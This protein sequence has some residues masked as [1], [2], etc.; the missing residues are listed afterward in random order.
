[1]LNLPD[2]QIHS[3]IYQ[4]AN[5]IVYRGYNPANN[6]PVILKLLRE[7]YPTPAELTRY[8]QEYRLTHQ[9]NIS[10]VIKAEALIEYGNTFIIVFEDFG[11]ESLKQLLQLQKFSLQ[12]CLQ[13]GIKI[14]ESLGNIHHAGIIHK[15]INPANIVYN[16]KT[17]QLKIID[18][19]IATLLNSENPTLQNPSV[20]EGTLAYISPEQTGRMNR[21]LD[22]RSDFYS[23]GV[24]L[25]EL[26]TGKLP[27][28]T[29]D[30]LELLHCHLAKQALS[31]SS[32]HSTLITHQLS[33]KE[34]AIL[35]II[36]QMSQKLMAKTAEE[37]YQSAWG[38][39]ADLEACLSRLE[40]NEKI[41]PFILGEKDRCDRFLIPE[42]LYGREQEIATL[43]AAFNAIAKKEG[44]IRNK[45]ILVSGYSGI[46]KSALVKE[47]YKPITEARGY[48]IWGKFEQ[49][50]R[51][52]P[53]SAVAIAFQSLIKQIL[54][55][56]AQALQQWKEKL[57]KALGENAQLIID[58][59]PEVELIIGKQKKIAGLSGIEAQN[60]FNWVFHRFMQVMA[61]SEHPLVLFIDDLQWADS[62]TLKL[63]QV[64]IT[65]T[66][67]EHLLLIGAY[68][69]N[70]VDTTHP[71][72]LVLEEL[73]KARI[74][75]DILH[76]KPLAQDSIDQLII[77]TLLCDC[78][79]SLSKLT[80]AKTQGNPFF[81]KEFIKT[82]YQEKLINFD[83]TKQQWS[84]NIEQIEE[85]NITD[86]VVE[87]MMSNLQKLSSVTQN[88]LS[89]AACLGSSFELRTLVIV[90][91][92]SSQEIF[93]KLS[94]AISIGL[95]IPTSDLDDQ[96]LYQD[97]KFLHD[98]I[99]QAA[100]SLIESSQLATLNL[101]IA[102][103]LLQNLSLEELDDKIFLIVD[104]Y[105][106]GKD[107]IDD[108]QEKEKL[109]NLNLQV[110]LKAKAS[111][112]FQSANRYLKIA[113]NLLNRDSWQ[114]NYQLTLEV[115]TTTAEITYIVNDYEQSLLFCET[116]KKQAK[117]VLDQVKV[118]QNQ[119]AIYIAQTKM[120]LAL[121]TAQEI[122]KLLDVSLI[123]EEPKIANSQDIMKLPEMVDEEKK[124]ALEILVS[125]FAPTYLH[126]SELLFPVS[127]TTIHLCLKYGN[128]SLS[129]N[130]YTW[131]V[132]IV[133]C[134]KNE[135]KFA[136]Q[137]GKK[138]LNLANNYS[139]ENKDHR[140]INPFYGNL[141]PW[142]KHY[143]ECT[144]PLKNA[145]QTLFEMGD[146]EYA[147]HCMFDYSAMA[148]AMGINLAEL[149]REL[150]YFMSL[151][152]NMGQ[153]LVIKLIN[154]LLGSIKKIINGSPNDL[155]ILS[156]NPDDYFEE[157]ESLEVFSNMD[158]GHVY[159]YFGQ[160]KKAYL[161]FQKN[162][163]HQGFMRAYFP[164]VKNNF[165]YSL[166]SLALY[167]QAS[168]EEQ[169]KYL[170]IVN[171][172]QKQMKIWA[173][174]AP[175]NFQHKYDLVAAETARVLGNTLEAIE[176]Y[177]QAI[178]RAK[179]NQ[180]VHEEALANELAAYFYLAR[181]QTKIAA[182]YLNDAHY[183]YLK[184][185]ANAKVKAL[186]SEYP[187][188]LTQFSNR[189]YLDLNTTLSNT[190]TRNLNEQ[191]DLATVIKTSKALSQEAKLENLLLLLSK[192]LVKN[193]GAQTGLI[194]L[195]KE[196]KL[197]LEI[198]HQLDDVNNNLEHKSNQ[199]LP[200][201]II[202]YVQRTQ[203]ILVLDNASSTGI[204]TKDKY[205]QNHQTKSVLCLPLLSQGKTIGILYLENNLSDCVFNEDRLEVV[206]LI[207]S[208]A[209]I[210]IE[211]ALLRKQEENQIYS[212]QVGGCLEPNSPTYVVRKAD[213]DL[214]QAL[215]KGEFCYV[216][217]SRHMGK[218]SLRVQ[219][220]Q[221]LSQEGYACSAIDLTAIG[222]SN[223]KE[224]QWYAGLIYKLVNSFHLSERFNFRDWWKSLDFLS[225]M[226]KFSEFIEQV[227]L[228]QIQSKII[229]F[230]DEI[231]STISLK[232]STDD[233]F[234]S[235]R[236]IYNA[237]AE[238]KE[239]HRLSFVLLGVATPSSLIQNKDHT[240]FNIG[241]A[242]TLAGFKWE[243]IK[244]LVKGLEGKY[245]QA[246]LLV[247]EVLIWT[248]GQPFLTQKICNL[249]RQSTQVIESGQE[250]EWV[251]NLVTTQIIDNWETQDEP[252]HLKT[253]RDRLLQSQNSV[254]LLQLLQWILTEGKVLLDSSA[255]QRELLLSGIVSQEDQYLV[256]FN[257]IYQQ[258]FTL[259]WLEERILSIRSN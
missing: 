84:W 237:R 245:A 55:E 159:F 137:L 215:N 54:C 21:S 51:D 235:I 109:I 220:M 158:Q 10:G 102:R 121:D 175:M 141:L 17:K 142:I 135:L 162:L 71:L 115:Y 176:L 234:A 256:M 192:F 186:E 156:E 31:V 193:T 35:E 146:I 184:W 169:Q 1:M 258:V 208:Q 249:I 209:A 80:L 74:S 13:L 79:S 114:T 128:T 145:I 222:S 199:N 50:Q 171:T 216:L 62:A 223:L 41:Q 181:K 100:H 45:L 38:I 177:D 105:N 224:E 205:I 178:A 107:L 82:L 198:T 139:F 103:L 230:I 48:F 95:I 46:G 23:L 36:D 22:Y 6:K 111:A 86:N 101:R 64:L 49:Y 149:E 236:A 124:A 56:S 93:E 217:N 112:A 96:L 201:G 227:L 212:Y 9:L 24:S 7:N 14:S 233:F 138:A 179:A 97:Y 254:D 123:Y 127:Y 88:I 147:G 240:P 16:P 248:C 157:T 206:K 168:A 33:E 170:A 165:Y 173:E 69:D 259:D 52:I 231:D 172:N 28:E 130:A 53:Y 27:F 60:R 194:F 72:T 122:L 246:E 58:V 78:V 195:E 99:Q 152:Q 19:G 110:A 197:Q 242:I 221:Q 20:L 34:I 174:N 131:Y 4:S 252:Q 94:E 155:Q 257:P 251:A 241:T 44:A 153:G 117:T 187:Q 154:L 68:R 232:F 163:K 66:Q 151:L 70:E 211:N 167:N 202:N 164:W 57:V 26:I 161:E 247:K 108:D 87:L 119:I 136:Y 85:Q 42:K 18:F 188:L 90:A 47:L 253:I 144:K 148:Y 43:L 238:R 113:I 180:Y 166:S 140:S 61:T 243:S 182:V 5:S 133:L 15:D 196:G 204:F 129:S 8:Q 67:I 200:S 89:L 190:T 30:A 125:M 255:S 118:Y 132:G 191:L 203:E 39:K 65:D 92:K 32:Y 75:W 210:A 183:L 219:M 207:S 225:P 12:E 226:Q 228:Q 3:Q 214:Y 239:Y 29:E 218:S 63:I 160:Y 143:R 126:Q 250:S 98:R 91:E 40:T 134:E 150:Q 106:L 120:E 11:G 185:G 116:V 81:V 83:I 213:Q 77:E 25:Y 76:L 73:K 189:R 37:R 244:P 59:I 229:I 2:Y 104:S